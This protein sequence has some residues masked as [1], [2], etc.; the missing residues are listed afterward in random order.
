MGGFHNDGRKRTSYSS[1]EIFRLGEDT[2]KEGTALPR[3]LGAV[4]S[5]SLDNIIYITGEMMMLIDWSS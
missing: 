4:R 1:T 5:T 2:W 3:P